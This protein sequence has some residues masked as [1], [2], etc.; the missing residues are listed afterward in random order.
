MGGNLI[1]L[2]TTDPAEQADG[3]YDQS[4]VLNSIL[5]TIV[6]KLKVS[7]CNL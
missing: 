2:Q 1:C 5:A 4:I 7:V 3:L 6:W